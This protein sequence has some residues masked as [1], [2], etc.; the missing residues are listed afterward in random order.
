MQPTKESTAYAVRSEWTEFVAG[1]RR[2]SRLTRTVGLRV[3]ARPDGWQLALRTEALALDE[4]TSTAFD[5]IGRLVG[6]LYA[7]LVLDPAPRPVPSNMPLLVDAG[8]GRKRQIQVRA[9]GEAETLAAFQALHAANPTLPLTLF[10]DTDVRV[11]EARLFLKNDCQ[12]VELAKS[13]VLLF[14][15]E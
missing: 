3:A 12:Q 15:A 6:G 9:F 8:Y 5:E 2:L 13:P 14:D 11:D 7:D 4:P 1:E 10:I